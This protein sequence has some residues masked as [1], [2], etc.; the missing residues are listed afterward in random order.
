MEHLESPIKLS[1][2]WLADLAE[3]VCDR[4][5]WIAYHLPPPLPS[6]IPSVV[7]DIDRQTRRAVTASLQRHGR[8]PDW[9]PVVGDVKSVV[10]DARLRPRQFQLLDEGNGVLLRGRPDVVFELADGSYH[11]VDYKATRPPHSGPPPKRYRIQ[12]NAYALVAEAVGLKPVSGLSLVF[13]QA[14][15]LLQA[16]KAP[17]AALRFDAQRHDVA[18]N[19]A[20]WVQPL[21]RRA[22]RVLRQRRPPAPHPECTDCREL[23]RWARHLLSTR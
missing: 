21:L 15:P 19:P 16:R 1:V 3:C 20:R 6:Q 17:Y 23:K 13:L 14:G 18:L 9:H 10:P 5:Y 4:C 11:I 22:S 12:L 8:L 7:R 2:T